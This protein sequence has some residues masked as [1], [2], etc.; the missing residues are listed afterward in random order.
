MEEKTNN[1]V[2]KHARTYNK[3]HVMKDRKK[4]KKKGYQKHKG[5]M[6]E[7]LSASDDAGEWVKDFRKSDAPQFKGKSD[8][9]KQQMA[10]AAYLD[11]KDKKESVEVD[12]RNTMDLVKGALSKLS[13]KKKYEVA[14]KAVKSGK[15]KVGKAAQVYD[16]DP[17]TL[18][19]LALESFEMEEKK[20]KGLWDNIHA[21]RKR[22]ERPAKPGE[23]GYPKTLDVGEGLKQ[24]RKNVGSDKCWDGYK[25]TGTKMKGGKE[26][27][28]C[29]KE[30]NLDE[31]SKSTMQSYVG[32][33][34]KS[35]KKERDAGGQ[36]NRRHDGIMRAH[37]KLRKEGFD[38]KANMHRSKDATK[39]VKQAGKALDQNH[40]DTMA[41]LRDIQKRKGMKEDA[42]VRARMTLKH[43]QEK[44]TLKKKQ[45]RERDSIKKESVNEELSALE[46]RKYANLKRRAKSGDRTAKSQLAKFEKDMESKIAM[47]KG[48]ASKAKK[49][50]N[51]KKGVADPHSG[52]GYSGKASEKGAD[53]HIIMQ[54]RKAQDVDGKMDIKA[55]PTGK[56]VRLPKSLIDKLLKMH[57]AMQKPDDKRRLRIMITKELRKRAK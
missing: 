37:K 29:K 51:Y 23:K 35:D 47:S 33:A 18:Q 1:L 10:I 21:K 14:L 6:Y 12:E 5:K 30:E 17:K 56:T 22:G 26:V 24:A 19:D 34:L 25:A 28:D 13:N 54:L 27:P 32:K 38:V 43:A 52:A 48:S 16:V 50:G 31:L 9:K 40:K 53:D 49:V 39:F 15:Y 45:E 2:A 57:D 42:E 3:S 8:K 7:K 55:T 11:A 4:A 36:N 20:N 41:A 46:K 44:E